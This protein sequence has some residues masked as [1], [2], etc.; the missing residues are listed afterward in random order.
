MTVRIAQLVESRIV[1]PV[2]VG[3]SPISHPRISRPRGGNIT[4]SFAMCA[5]RLRAT[6]RRSLK[7][8]KILGIFDLPRGKQGRRGRGGGTTIENTFPASLLLRRHDFDRS[9][10]FSRSLS[11][12][13]NGCARRRSVRCP[14]L[15]EGAAGAGFPFVFV[16]LLHRF[17]S[18]EFFCCSQKK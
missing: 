11:V 1:I 16:V 2:V 4:G 3:S 17:R 14:S 9:K 5:K 18:L 13:R 10:S 8:K 12:S 15:A 7:K 6:R